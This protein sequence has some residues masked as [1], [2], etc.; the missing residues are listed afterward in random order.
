VRALGA[1]LLALASFAGCG[2]DTRD[3]EQTTPLVFSCESHADCAVVP[4]SCCG[5]CGAPT[6]DDAIAVSVD[7]SDEYR[8]QACEGVGG[9]PACAPLFVDPRLLGLC[10][11]E[12][13]E[14][15]RL[16]NHPVAACTEDA[17][18]EV[19]TRDCCPCGGETS[20]GRLIAIRKD[21]ASYYRDLVCDPDQ[22]CPEC[23]P[24]YPP[25]VTARCG[26]DAFCEA[27]DTRLP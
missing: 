6:K 22:G 11:G 4:E 21:G 24:V 9:C 16:H 19:R 12:R 18:C 5:A 8:A 17:E 10:Q 20:P 3:G 15:V 26:A 13:C 25:E 1:A 7:K 23:E 2:G 27:I 14:L